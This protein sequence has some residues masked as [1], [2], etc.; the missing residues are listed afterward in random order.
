VQENNLYLFDLFLHE[1]CPWETLHD[2]HKV[3]AI[4]ILARLIAKA[5]LRNHDEGKDHE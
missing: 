5:G 2:E 1:T 4:D 3:L